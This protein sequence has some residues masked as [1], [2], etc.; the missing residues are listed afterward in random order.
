MSTHREPRHIRLLVAGV[1]T[2]AVMASV[3]PAVASDIRSTRRE[4]SS[5][6]PHIAV[7]SCGP[8]T[9]TARTVF[10]APG[11]ATAGYADNFTELALH[12]S[13]GACRFI[14]PRTVMVRRAQGRWQS[15]ALE[16]ISTDRS[17]EIPG[18][19]TRDVVLGA[20]WPT[21]RAPKAT[22]RCRSPVYDVTTVRIPGVDITVTP[23]DR[24][25]R[26]CES[27]A[28][29]DLDWG[30]RAGGGGRRSVVL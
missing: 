25:A 28:S 16:N 13:H 12:D 24:F 30:P 4:G 20:S 23:A 2:V 8:D 14:I 17:Y 3:G 27:P 21:S 26:V 9:L 15:V 18:G 29:V 22:G 7:G 11:S 6:P 5:T 19:A 10:S 1:A